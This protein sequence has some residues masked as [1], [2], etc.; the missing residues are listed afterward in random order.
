MGFGEFIWLILWGGIC[1][2]TAT[3]LIIYCMCLIVAA[4]A[5]QNTNVSIALGFM[6]A[7]FIFILVCAAILCIGF[8]FTTEIADIY[9]FEKEPL[10]IILTALS[11]VMA[12]PSAVAR[13]HRFFKMVHGL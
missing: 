5:L 6:T 8:Y 7:P 9:R 13:L 12:Y 4:L 1:G 11:A 10:F 2:L 3:N